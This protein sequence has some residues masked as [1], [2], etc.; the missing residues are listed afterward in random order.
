[1]SSPDK[2]IHIYSV[3]YEMFVYLISPYCT[4]VHTV[5]IGMAK[6]DQQQTFLFVNRATV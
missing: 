4:D 6:A 5:R 2:R 3:N 1:M